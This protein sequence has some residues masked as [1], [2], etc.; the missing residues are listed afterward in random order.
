MEIQK[1]KGQNAIITGADS[2]IGRAIAIEFG[3]L[4]AN[5][6][7][8]YH[9]NKESADEVVE[10]IKKEGGDAFAC[11]ADV[12]VEEDVIGMFSASKEKF[13]AVDILINN[14]GLQKDA[15]LHEMTLEDWQT[16]IGVNL[17]GQF[18]CA[19]EAVRQFL[20]RGVV[21]EKSR[22]C[23]KIVCMSSVHD[24]IPWAGHVNYATS[25]GGILMMMKTMAQEL[26]PKKI[27]VNAI[28]P[29]AIKTPIN[30]E[31]WS[32]P[33]SAEKLLDIIPYKR[34]GEPEDVGKVAAWLVS[35]DADYI[36]GTTIYV[37]GGMT[38]YPAFAGNG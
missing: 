12:S 10:I 18:L 32:D 8:N 38:L 13:G 22:A 33:E 19:R 36:T 34:I 35:D 14:A 7:V 9:S 31:V 3:K 16:V 6:T 30:E 15:A 11:K 23:G 29:G 24:I 2:G 4:G 26:A 20:E 28:S 5:V 17:T 27:R 1:I 25:K 21:P 37:D